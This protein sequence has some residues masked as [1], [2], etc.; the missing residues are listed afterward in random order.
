MIIEIPDDIPGKERARLL[1]VLPMLYA[2]KKLNTRKDASDFLNIS[3][4]TIQKI[5]RRNPELRIFALEGKKA[6]KIA[7]FFIPIVADRL[8]KEIDIQ[9]TCGYRYAD[10]LEKDVIDFIVLKLFELKKFAKKNS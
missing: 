9:S 8:E 10:R 3:V 7:N 6:K 5:I 4:R 2:L 1:E